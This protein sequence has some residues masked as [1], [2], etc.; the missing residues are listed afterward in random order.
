MNR[1]R[2][3]LAQ[4]QEEL[5]R[6]LVREALRYCRWNFEKAAALLDVS[7]TTIW[8]MTVKHDIEVPESGEGY[9]RW[10]RRRRKKWAKRDVA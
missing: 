10:R 1:P 8:R 4:R 7:R 3:T 6:R 9:L 2:G 5:E